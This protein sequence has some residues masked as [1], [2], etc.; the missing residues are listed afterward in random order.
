MLYYEDGK[1]IV[2]EETIATGSLP[3]PV[4]NAFHKKFPNGKITLAEKL[5]RDSS[6]TY[7]LQVKRKDEIIEIVF[8]RDGKELEPQ[9]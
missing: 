1:L 3:K 4:Q 6:V 9:D 2:V 5:T 7:E 8:D